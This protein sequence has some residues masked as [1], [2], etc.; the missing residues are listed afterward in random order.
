MNKYPKIAKAKKLLNWY[1]RTGLIVGLKKT[2]NFYKK[3]I[4]FY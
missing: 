4:K 3:N 2:I 1:P